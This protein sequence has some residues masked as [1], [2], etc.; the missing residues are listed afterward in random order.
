MN[1][2]PAGSG[3]QWGD[4]PRPDAAKDGLSRNL[5]PAARA[6]LTDREAEALGKIKNT[7][8]KAKYVG[9]ILGA[10]GGPLLARRRK[11]EI[12]PIPLAG[13][14]LF[15]AFAGA[16]ILSPLG[17]IWGQKYLKEVEDPRHLAQVLAGAAEE[18]R[19]RRQPPR[20]GQAPGGRPNPAQPQSGAPTSSDRNDYNE[21][22]S[23][24]ALPSADYGSYASNSPGQSGS[25][26]GGNQQSY[27]SNP[28]PSSYER[29][30]PSS[31]GSRWAELRGERGTTS[32]RWEELRQQSAREEMQ[33]QRQQ[34]QASMLGQSSPQQQQQQQ[35]NQPILADPTFGKGS[36]ENRTREQ[37]QFD[38][39]MEKE[40]RGQDGASS[41]GV[42]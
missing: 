16:F 41:L 24:S 42:R 27:S 9:Y 28:G 8:N 17:I 4:S 18:R 15:G 34:G 29:Q 23:P 35:Q 7:A 19:G 20:P 3:S 10:V 32:S 33:Q 1:S 14:S 11:P 12:K 5:G 40:R 37:Q 21:G 31:S 22:I 13:W 26:Y 39:M 2:A 25:Q 36:G 6:Q 30:E 38:A